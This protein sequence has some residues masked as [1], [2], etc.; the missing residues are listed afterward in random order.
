LLG[1]I[2]DIKDCYAT[3]YEKGL[4]ETL[5]YCVALDT[6]A[7]ITDIVHAQSLR[8]AR[9]PYFHDEIYD[10]R[11][12]KNMAAAGINSP[13]DQT[14][15]IDATKHQLN[16]VAGQYVRRTVGNL[17]PVEQ[18]AFITEGQRQLNTLL[19]STDSAARTRK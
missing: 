4:H 16:I 19:P 8:V 18:D 13:Y 10:A 17:S 5:L 2:E 3:A 12:R 6:Q 11:V 14:S 15:V 9:R 7:F 1:V